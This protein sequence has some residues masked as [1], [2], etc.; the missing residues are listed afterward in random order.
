MIDVIHSDILSVMTDVI[1]KLG[2]RKMVRTIKSPEERK[3]D[4]L[5]AAEKLFIEKG[6]EQTVV[7]DIVKAAGIAQGTF[8]IYY[9]SKEDIFVAVLERVMEEDIRRLI[10]VEQ[11]KDLN[12]IEKLNL[13]IM[14]EF[15]LDRKHDDL[16]LQ[17]HLPVNTGVH[18]KYI[19]NKIERLIPIYASIIEQGVREGLLNNKCPRESSEFM[20][21]ATK[22]MF[23]PGIFDQST[24]SL[25][26]RI[27]AVQDI[28]ERILGAAKGSIACPDVTVL[29]KGEE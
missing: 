27:A 25:K 20:L 8:Y 19:I 11:R 1:H 15:S 10:E 18:Q 29:L 26:K 7:S 23:D 6:Y 24:G 2:G 13:I 22:F 4:I 12:A 9:K 28:Y 5:E 16:V 21:I 3:K 17:M 14:L